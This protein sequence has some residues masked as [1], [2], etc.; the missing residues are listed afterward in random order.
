MRRSLTLLLAYCMKG[1]W[2]P[3]TVPWYFGAFRICRT[4]SLAPLTPQL[5]LFFVAVKAGGSEQTT[6]NQVLGFAAS[7]L[8]LWPTPAMWQCEPSSVS[9][10]QSHQALWFALPSSLSCSASTGVGT[11]GYASAAKWARAYA[12]RSSWVK[13]ACWVLLPADLEQWLWWY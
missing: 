12:G 11:W 10:N 9:S 6:T 5:S 13:K 1:V 2:C 8:A 4:R 3:S 7:V